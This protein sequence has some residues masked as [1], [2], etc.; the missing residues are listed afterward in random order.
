MVAYVGGHFYPMLSPA[1]R[2]KMKEK[3]VRYP[4]NYF[5]VFYTS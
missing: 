4:L 3:E 1:H 2:A 5:G